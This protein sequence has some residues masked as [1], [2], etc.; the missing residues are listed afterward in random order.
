MVRDDQGLS[1]IAGSLRDLGNNFYQQS[2]TESVSISNRKN[3]DFRFHYDDLWA[4][5]I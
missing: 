1:G 4:H 3:E 2:I 5:F